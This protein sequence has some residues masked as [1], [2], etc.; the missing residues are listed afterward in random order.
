M[1]LFCLTYFYD[2]LSKFIETRNGKNAYSSGTGLQ[3]INIFLLI[4]PELNYCIV[5][6]LKSA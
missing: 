3:L 6:F 1:V 5:I 4:I 2:V